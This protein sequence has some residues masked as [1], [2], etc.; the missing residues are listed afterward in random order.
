MPRLTRACADFAKAS[1]MR[2]YIDLGA[3]M[4]DEQVALSMDRYYSTAA[5]VAEAPAA[6]M[7]EVAA[8]AEALRRMLEESVAACDQSALTRLAASMVQDFCRLVTP[9]GGTH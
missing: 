3:E 4:S 9:A 7:E 1:A 6:T 8:K 5:A 2:R